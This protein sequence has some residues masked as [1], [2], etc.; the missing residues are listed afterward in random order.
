MIKKKISEEQITENIIFQN[1]KEQLLS[2]SH[3]SVSNSGAKKEL[4]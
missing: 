2:D 4:Y 1:S 3:T